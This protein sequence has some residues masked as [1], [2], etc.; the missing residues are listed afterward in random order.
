[1]DEDRKEGE[2][3]LAAG[4]QRLE[5]IERKLAPYM[6][7]KRVREGARRGEW[8]SDS[9]FIRSHTPKRAAKK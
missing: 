7:K 4:R 6:P 8:R 5:D 3:R 1:M 2:A 9:S